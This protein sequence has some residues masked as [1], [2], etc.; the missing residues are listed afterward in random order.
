MPGPT[1]LAILVACAPEPASPILAPTSPAAAPVA[2]PAEVPVAFVVPAD[3]TIPEGPLGDAIRRGR[4]LA[5]DT[6]RLAP[7]FAGNDLAQLAKAEAAAPG[8]IVEQAEAPARKVSMSLFVVMV[9]LL[10]LSIVV[11]GVLLLRGA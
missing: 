2:S 9:V 1:L 10:F 8:V 7:D 3:S 4:D 11:N 5:N 6:R